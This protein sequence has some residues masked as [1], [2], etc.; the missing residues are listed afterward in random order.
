MTEDLPWSNVALVTREAPVQINT[1]ITLSEEDAFIFNNGVGTTKKR[2]NHP[3]DLLLGI[4][5]ER[6]YP[7]ELTPVTKSRLIVLTN[8]NTGHYEADEKREEV[9]EEYNVLCFDGGLR[10]KARLRIA[11]IGQTPTFRF[12]SLVT[13]GAEEPLRVNTNLALAEQIV[14]GEYSDVQEQFPDVEHIGLNPAE[15]SQCLVTAY[16][17]RKNFIL[18]EPER[19]RVSLIE[20]AVDM[21]R[22]R[23][24]MPIGS[25]AWLHYPPMSPKEIE[26]EVQ[27]TK[28]EYADELRRVVE[29]GQSVGVDPLPARRMREVVS[30]LVDRAEVF[31]T[32]K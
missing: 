17:K 7:F 10:E 3:N 27:K 19:R 5:N 14:A 29:M 6:G 8:P 16:Q 24:K 9:K 28:E 11:V 26:E 12:L 15:K 4:L 30:S 20:S 23:D 21:K 13:D 2:P 18:G 32:G 31:L 22:W 1:L 25:P